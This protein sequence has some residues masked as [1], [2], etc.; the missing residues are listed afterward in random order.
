MTSVQNFGYYGIMVWLPMIL[1]KEHGLSTSSMSGWMVV[2]VIGMIA[3]IYVFGYL[4]DRFGRK[5]RTCSSTCVRQ[6][7]C[8]CMSI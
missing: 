5:N 6:R 1:L 2:T 8:M 4:S 3:G 7:W